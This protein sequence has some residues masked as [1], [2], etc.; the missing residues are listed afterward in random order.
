MT[1]MDVEKL[2]F[3]VARLAESLR[4]EK[5]KSK[6]LFERLFST[7]ALLEGANVESVRLA[8]DLENVQRRLDE[9]QRAFLLLRAFYKLRLMRRCDESA[10]RWPSPRSVSSDDSLVVL[11][12]SDC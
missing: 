2:Q 1:E 12:R 11:D 10:V 4:W 6:S 9:N 5:L 8:R 3:E 7:D